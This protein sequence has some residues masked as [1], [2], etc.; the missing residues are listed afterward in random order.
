MNQLVI[1]HKLD[2]S[3]NMDVLATQIQADIE[4][5][6]NLVVT[7]DSVADTKKLMSEI[8]KE[9][10]DFKKKYKEFKNAVLEPFTPLD[11]KAKEI[12]KY[13]EEAREA[14]DK[15]VKAFEETKREQAKIACISYTKE[16]CEIK[17]INFEAITILDLFTK[18]GSITTTGA[19]SGTAKKEIDQR[20]AVVENEILKA[21]L[22]A[23]EKAKRDREIAENA[24]L[25]AEEKAKQREIQLLANAEIEKQKA[26]QEALATKPVEEI[27][28]QI[29]VEQPEI[30]TDE[31]VKEIKFSVTVTKQQ[32]DLINRFLVDNNIKFKAL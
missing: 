24:R 10:D 13:Y 30:I 18:L 12:E 23:E 2:I 4:H 7:E 9:K 29:E 1:N 5:K 8:N 6:Y 16:Q 19:I 26:V 21:K 20:I 27:K 11:T 31:L 3:S 15:Q 22:E 25:E 28:P 14:L 32:L 17:D